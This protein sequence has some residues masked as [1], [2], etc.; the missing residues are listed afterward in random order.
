MTQAHFQWRKGAIAADVIRGGAGLLVCVIVLGASGFFSPGG[1]IAAGLGALFAAHITTSALKVSC[2]VTLDDEGASMTRVLL[3]GKCV[4]W[5]DV[6]S[7]AVRHFPVGQSRRKALMDL[8]LSD[9]RTTLLLD[10]GLDDFP[11]AVQLAWMAART[12]GID[13]SETTL[14]NLAAAGCTTQVASHNA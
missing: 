11:R 13:V 8:K 7:F 4:R 5:R 1:V 9:G 10:E 6:Q 3:P 14:T 2:K 12:H